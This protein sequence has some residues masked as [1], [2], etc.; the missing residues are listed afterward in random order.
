MKRDYAAELQF[1]NSFVRTLPADPDLANRPRQVHNAG[2]TRVEPTRVAAP[3]LLAWS[4]ELGQQLG[5]ARPVAAADPLVEV[6]A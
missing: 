6:F 3:R 5:I 1:D 2:Y 4:D